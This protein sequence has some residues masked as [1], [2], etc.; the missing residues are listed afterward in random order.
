MDR[1]RYDGR[2]QMNPTI[3]RPMTTGRLGRGADRIQIRL[4]R[5]IPG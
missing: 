1:G 2:E 5:L 4:G 3:P